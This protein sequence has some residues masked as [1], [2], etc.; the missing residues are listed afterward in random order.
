MVDGRVSMT[1]TI[2]SLSRAFLIVAAL[3]LAPAAAK[4][5]TAGPLESASSGSVDAYRAM[6]ITVGVVGGAIVATVLTEGLVL[7]LLS[8]TGAADAAARLV[9]VSGTVFG[10]VAGGLY[11]DDWY[12][13]Q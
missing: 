7:P 13:R 2:V 11:A 10:A 3:A 8:G 5:Q 1:K 6:A 4:A 9:G 12:A